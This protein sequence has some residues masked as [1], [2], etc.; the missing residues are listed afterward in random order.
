MTADLV[1]RLRH[2]VLE[3]T[4]HRKVHDHLL[5]AADEIERLRERLH[6]LEGRCSS[7]AFLLQ[8]PIEE[9]TDGRG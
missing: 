1:K 6:K 4:P 8:A 9:A 5:E 7:A 2:M 3:R